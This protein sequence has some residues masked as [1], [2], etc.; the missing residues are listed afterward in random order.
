MGGALSLCDRN[1]EFERHKE[2]KLVVPNMCVRHDYVNAFLD[3]IR[4][5]KGTMGAFV[6][7]PSVD[8]LSECL[9]RMRQSIRPSWWINT[10][11]EMDIACIVAAELFLLSTV[12]AGTDHNPGDP[13][14]DHKSKSKKR[15]MDIKA[16]TD[17]NFIIM[18]MKYVR[19]LQKNSDPS[20]SL[21]PKE[22]DRL[23]LVTTKK[24]EAYPE[25]SLQSL[26]LLPD[27]EL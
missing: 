22:V 21:L 27:D 10:R 19:A 24:D 9:H 12:T 23:G 16:I 5:K 8:T 4:G 15:R 17:E 26:L 6:A 3:H 20:Q 1:V 13:G 14:D 18:E 2:V 7:N 11:T 25:E